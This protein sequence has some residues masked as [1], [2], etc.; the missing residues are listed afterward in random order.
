MATA[1]D[2]QAPPTPGAFFDVPGAPGGESQWLDEYET[3]QALNVVLSSA[4]QIQVN[5]IQQFKQTDVVLDWYMELNVTQTYTAGTSAL[6]ASVYAPHNLVGPIKLSIQN[7]YASV[8]V[9]SGIDLY[10][11]GLIRPS[12]HSDHIDIMAANP[13]GDWTGSTATG[14]QAA[15]NAQANLVTPGQWATGT[16]T[17]NLFYRIPASQWFDVY[18]D[19][20]F[21][22]QLTGMPPHAAV[23]SPQY[24]AGTTRVITPSMKANQG[25]A[26]TTD[27]GPVNIGAG[28]GTFT[29]N[30]NLTFRRQG[31]IGR[32]HV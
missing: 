27:V 10:I 5:G 30:F 7:Q 4:N 13:E 24:M 21:D 25:N 14:Y 23:V 2:Q 22:G 32:A 19:R 20:T 8:D 17:Y 16:A 11:F 1:T 18:Y 3:T 9:E 31:E 26:A 6:T 12:R 15:A 29:G 28:T